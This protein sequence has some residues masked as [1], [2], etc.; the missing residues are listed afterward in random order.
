[1]IQ[2]L[3]DFKALGDYVMRF[4][5]L[6]VDDEANT[7]RIVLIPG[8]VQALSRNLM[9]CHSFPWRIGSALKVRGCAQ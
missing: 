9:H 4:S 2:V 7:T 3:Q 5:A 6:D 1:M 8:I